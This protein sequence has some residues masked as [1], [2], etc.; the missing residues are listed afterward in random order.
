M[1]QKLFLFDVSNYKL[2]KIIEIN[3]EIAPDLSISTLASPS[4]AMLKK[5]EN[6]E[7]KL[8]FDKKTKKWTGIKI[9][10]SK[11]DE[12]MLSN[13]IDWVDHFIRTKL[14][15]SFTFDGVEFSMEDSKCIEYNELMIFSIIDEVKFPISIKGIGNIYKTIDSFGQLKNLMSAMRRK[16]ETLRAIGRAIK[17]GGIVNGV[18]IKP[19]ADDKL[20]KMKSEEIGNMVD[21]TIAL[22][23]SGVN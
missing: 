19:I 23:E 10:G 18:S 13:S 17:Y 12:A 5:W 16:K 9:D 3:D 8:V 11:I 20:Y 2:Y 21:S 7:V 4:K 15:S 1:A 14:R 22:V 6:K